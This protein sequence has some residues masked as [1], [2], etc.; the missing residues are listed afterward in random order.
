MLAGDLDAVARGALTA[1][2]GQSFS[3]AVEFQ[4]ETPAGG[5]QEHGQGALA[6]AI[7]SRIAPGILG[8][9]GHWH[10]GGGGLGKG[11]KE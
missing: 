3:Q 4:H 9:Q 10:L 11:R 5:F 1:D 7:G 8:S 2:Q 6:F